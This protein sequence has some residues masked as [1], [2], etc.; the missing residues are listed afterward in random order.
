RPRA[1][2]ARDL[3]VVDDGDERARDG[4][5]LALQQVAR[6]A[7]NRAAEDARREA[8]EQ[9]TSDVGIEHDGRFRGR[10]LASAELGDRAARRLAPDVFGRFE[11]GE[12]SMRGPVMSASLL[13]ALVFGHRGNDE[14]S[15]R[16]TL[17]AGEAIREDHGAQA[18]AAGERGAFTQL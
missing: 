1:E 12:V 14:R 6:L 10:D 9:R 18:A 2:R 5:A 3:R 15:I 13:S 4:G 8:T 11:A 17:H 7:P 16:A